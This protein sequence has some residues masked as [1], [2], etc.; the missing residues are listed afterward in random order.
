VYGARLRPIVAKIAP[1]KAKMTGKAQPMT[2]S[3]LN[4]TPWLVGKERIRGNCRNSLEP[5]LYY[6]N[7]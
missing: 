4:L 3:T 5:S 2:E 6:K 1:Y 7:T